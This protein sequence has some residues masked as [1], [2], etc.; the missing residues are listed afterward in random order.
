[1]LLAPGV[2]PV[3]RFVRR[4]RPR[5]E[6]ALAG[7]GTERAQDIPVGAILDAFADGLHVQ[8]L[9]RAQTRGTDRPAGPV[10]G[11]AVHEAAVYLELVKRQVTP[12]PPRGMTGS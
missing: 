5:D 2:A 7:L 3:A 12:L 10:T 6:V 9:R 11:S 4:H 1:M 8:L